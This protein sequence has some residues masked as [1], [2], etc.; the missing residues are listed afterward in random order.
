MTN[1]L[2]TAGRA[3]LNLAVT[4][5]IA[6]FVCCLGALLWDRL[7]EKTEKTVQDTVNLLFGLGCLCSFFAVLLGFAAH[8]RDYLS[9]ENFKSV[10]TKLFVLACLCIAMMAGAILILLLAPNLFTLA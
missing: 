6:L 7:D 1:A 9:L 5:N 2:S 4:V 10:R 3:Q 8:N